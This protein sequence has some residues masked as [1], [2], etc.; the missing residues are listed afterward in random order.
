M[1]DERLERERLK[2]SLQFAKAFGVEAWEPCDK[3]TFYPLPQLNKATSFLNDSCELENMKRLLTTPG[4]VIELQG[5]LT[6]GFYKEGEP[7]VFYNGPSYI[8]LHQI[9]LKIEAAQKAR[10]QSFRFHVISKAVGVSYPYLIAEMLH[11]MVEKHHLPDFKM[12]LVGNMACGYT[13]STGWYAFGRT[14]LAIRLMRKYSSSTDCFVCGRD[15]GIVNCNTILVTTVDAEKFE[16]FIKYRCERRFLPDWSPQEVTD[17]LSKISWEDGYKTSKQKSPKATTPV[18]DRRSGKGTTVVK[19]SPSTVGRKATDGRCR[20]RAEETIESY[21]DNTLPVT[22]FQALEQRMLGYGMR[23]DDHQSYLYY[24]YDVFDLS[25]NPFTFKRHSDPN[26]EIAAASSKFLVD[27]YFAGATVPELRRS[28]A[29]KHPFSRLREVE[30]T[31]LCHLTLCNRFVRKNEDAKDDV[32]GNGNE[33]QNQFLFL[34]LDSAQCGI[35]Y[36][37][38][39]LRRSAR[40]GVHAKV[41]QL[42]IPRNGQLQSLSADR[43]WLNSTADGPFYVYLDEVQKLFLP[44]VDVLL[45][46]P[47]AFFC[48]CASGIFRSES[49]NR[50]VK[51]LSNLLMRFNLSGSA[52]IWKRYNQTRVSLFFIV[53]DENLLDFRLINEPALTASLTRPGCRCRSKSHSSE[54]ARD[55]YEPTLG[56]SSETNARSFNATHADDRCRWCRC[57]QY[58]NV[59]VLGVSLDNPRLSRAELKK[60]FPNFDDQIYELNYSGEI[61]E[62]TD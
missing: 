49:E 51:T 8:K 15:V 11:T 13:P 26:F 14:E 17:R 22:L 2:A 53:P 59:R 43:G 60:K 32:N 52:E 5:P 45:C 40:K 29:S 25:I 18:I 57:L 23:E 39:R 24:R 34:P 1:F 56:P 3:E 12:I 48:F 54:V 9:K 42:H 62:R 7:Y 30:F 46:N 6:W 27:V 37:A 21:R 41:R 10:G 4:S 47:L 55:C 28:I 20:D 36:A 38:K 19:A 35:P 33:E 58:L 61:V 44:G 16:N 31:K 50:L